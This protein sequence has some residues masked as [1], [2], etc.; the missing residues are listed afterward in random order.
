MDVY[1][2]WI[3]DAWDSLPAEAIAKS[4]KGWFLFYF[5]FFFF[6]VKPSFSSS[7]CGITICHDGSEDTQVHCFKQHGPIP[8]GLLKLHMARQAIADVDAIEEVDVE[9]DE[10]NGY[11]SE[12]SLEFDWNDELNAP[13]PEFHAF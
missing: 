4:F 1:L 5:I 2:Q 11:M 7:D 12:E 13:N 6:F 3:I 10:E 8:E 9:Q